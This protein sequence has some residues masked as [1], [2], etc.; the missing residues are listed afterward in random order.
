MAFRHVTVMGDHAI[1]LARPLDS[2]PFQFALPIPANANS[3]I[4]TLTA[5]GV[6]LDRRTVESRIKV[7]IERPDSPV[8]I[9]SDLPSLLVNDI[10]HLS[11]LLITGS[12]ADGASVDLTYSTLTSYASSDP[13]VATVNLM[14]FVTA[15][16]PGSAEITITNNGTSVVVPIKVA[17]PRNRER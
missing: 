13:A 10:G 2:P 11:Q 1:G 9:A 8:K 3:G 5:V 15:V 7:D 6:T 17:K 14:G 12:F 4:G 16:S